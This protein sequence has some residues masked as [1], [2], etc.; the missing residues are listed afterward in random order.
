MVAGGQG[1]LFGGN[2]H[3]LSAN[4]W[5]RNSTEELVAGETQE[6]FL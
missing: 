6:D 5:T 4:T 1:K 2:F 3:F